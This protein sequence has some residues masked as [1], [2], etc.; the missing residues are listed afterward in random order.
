LKF[1]TGTFGT[2]EP[3][4]LMCFGMLIVTTDSHVSLQPGIKKMTPFDN[5]NQLHNF[6][7]SKTGF[8]QVA[9]TILELAL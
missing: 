4:G 3:E 1:E 5:R 9:P 7:F 2:R 6:F 8:L